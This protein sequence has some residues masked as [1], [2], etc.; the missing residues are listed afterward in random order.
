[1]VSALVIVIA[2]LSHLFSAVAVSWG[3]QCSGSISKWVRNATS[4]TAT[5]TT[6]GPPEA[7]APEIGT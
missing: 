5:T 3:V 1:M 7:A 6:M 4:S 2:F